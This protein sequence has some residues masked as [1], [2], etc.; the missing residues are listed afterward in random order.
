MRH[1]IIN[2]REISLKA[3][4]AHKYIRERFNYKLVE[5]LFYNMVSEI[6]G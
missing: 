3:N 1:V 6:Y 2:S 4:V 5:N